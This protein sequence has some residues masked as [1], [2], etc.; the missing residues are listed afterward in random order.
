[1]KIFNILHKS[2]DGRARKGLLELP[3]RTVRTPVFMTVGTS[4]TVKA[5]TK[6]DLEEIGFEIILANTYHIF[7]R[8]GAALIQEAGGLSSFS[9]FEKSFLTDS[10]GFQVLSLS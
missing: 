8:Q 7:L 2:K 4:A 1:M 3:H 9:K 5:V 10:G 6:D